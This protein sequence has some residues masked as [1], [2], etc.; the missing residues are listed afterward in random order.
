[1]G[2]VFT[3]TVDLEKGLDSALQ[4]ALAAADAKKPAKIG[5]VGYQYELKAIVGTQGGVNGN[6][7]TVEVEADF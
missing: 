5:M 1:M 7:I 4:V 6:T 2:E 3:G